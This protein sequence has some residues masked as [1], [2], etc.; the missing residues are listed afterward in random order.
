MVCKAF[1][2]DFDGDQM[3]VH[4]P[5]SEEAQKEAKEIMLSSLN[6][7]KPATG[8]PVVSPTQ[9]II[10][11]CYWL[12]R[13][14]EGVLGEGKAFSSPEEAIMAYEHNNIDLRSKIKVRGIKHE[15][16]QNSCC[17]TWVHGKKPY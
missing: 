15:K 6:L 7:L 12:T 1:N 11:G 14:K 5:L 3:A 16:T 4:L 17:R 9:D 13:I 8:V 10:L 2:A